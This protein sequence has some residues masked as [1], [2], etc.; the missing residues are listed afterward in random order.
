MIYHYTSVNAFFNIVKTNQI[1]LMPSIH[2]NDPYEC[3]WPK[4][5]LSMFVI[6]S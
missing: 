3:F 2:T 5:I 1:R 6:I 4:V